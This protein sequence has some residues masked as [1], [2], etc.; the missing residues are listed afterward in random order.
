MFRLASADHL[1][2]ADNRVLND[3][4]LEEPNLVDVIGLA[5]DTLDGF[6]DVRDV[7]GQALRIARHTGRASASTASRNLSGKAFGVSTST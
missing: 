1:E 7:V 3:L 4:A 2:V 6:D 5:L